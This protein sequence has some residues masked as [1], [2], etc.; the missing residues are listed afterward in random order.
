MTLISFSISKSES[1]GTWVHVNLVSTWAPSNNALNLFR[2]SSWLL[3]STIDWT[4][5]VSSIIT[6]W[7]LLA[8]ID[9]FIVTD[10]LCIDLVWK[11]VNDDEDAD[12]VEGADDE[13][14]D[15][16]AGD[17]AKKEKA[18]EEAKEVEAN[19]EAR[20]EEDVDLPCMSTSE[21]V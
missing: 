3:G 12:I 6:T 2:S 8:E 4:T 17:E 16:K 14:D 11:I 7:S 10:C 20:D 5:F 18:N 15:E 13:T 19:D 1:L 21:P 9:S